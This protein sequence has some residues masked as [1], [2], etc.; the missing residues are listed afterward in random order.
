MTISLDEALMKTYAYGCYING[1]RRVSAFEAKRD[2]EWEC[3]ILNVKSS[4]ELPVLAFGY[5]STPFN[6]V[7][8]AIENIERGYEAAKKRAN[9]RILTHKTQQDVTIEAQKLFDE[10]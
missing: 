8:T 1:L 5:G 2:A 6:A 4:E 10:F 9:H 7:E 3:T